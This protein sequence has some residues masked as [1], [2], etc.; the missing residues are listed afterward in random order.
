MKGGKLMNTFVFDHALARTQV[1]STGQPT[2]D[3]GPHIPGLP[4]LPPPKRFLL[5][6]SILHT[7]ADTVY[8]FHQMGQRRPHLADVVDVEVSK[9]RIYPDKLQLIRT[10]FFFKR[11]TNTMSE[12][13]GGFSMLTY[14][15][16]K[17]AL[18]I[19][20]SF[21]YQSS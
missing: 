8:S 9:I 14:S 15:I 1:P 18:Y 11:H 21:P 16:E 6:G 17:R 5:P 2:G 10:M 13:K 12:V 3:W 7:S 4:M 20:T 19:I